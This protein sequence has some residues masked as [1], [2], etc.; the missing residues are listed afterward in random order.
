MPLKLFAGMRTLAVW[1]FAIAAISILGAGQAYAQVSGATLK[2]AVTDPTGAS[3]PK[4]QVSITDLATGI[5]HN[6][7]TDAAGTYAAA[8]LRPGD[9]QVRVT[10]TGFAVDMRSGITLTASA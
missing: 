6:V 5:I 7:P 2:G 8:N 1:I 10:A 4:A 3:V 9:Y